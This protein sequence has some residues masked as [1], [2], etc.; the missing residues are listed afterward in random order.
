MSHDMRKRGRESDKRPNNVIVQKAFTE[1][2][3]A[4]VQAPSNS[5]CITKLPPSTG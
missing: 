2:K 5:K 4:K 3:R 1:V